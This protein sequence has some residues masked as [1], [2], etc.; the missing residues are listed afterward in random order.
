MTTAAYIDCIYRLLST[1]NRSAGQSF[2]TSYKE[3]V[4]AI[5]YNK[6]H[7]HLRTTHTKHGTLLRKHTEHNGN[8]ISNPKG[9]YEYP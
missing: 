1:V 8:N 3:H 6:R 7:I 5:K 4:L 9:K 2:Q